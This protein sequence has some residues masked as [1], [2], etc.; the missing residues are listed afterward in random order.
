MVTTGEK[1]CGVCGSPASIFVSFMEGGFSANHAFCHLHAAKQGVLHPQG[2]D[3]LKHTVPQRAV[4]LACPRCAMTRSEFESRGRM[5][6]PGCYEAFRPTLLPILHKLHR[7][8]THK[9]KVPRRV[10][11]L[12]ILAHH[13][14]DLRRQMELAI[15]NES[16]EEAATL[17][18][19]IDELRRTAVA[20]KR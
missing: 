7:A 19:R 3:L 11:A 15:G 17:R 9:G 6:C 10:A 2:Y 14:I 1:C 16:F 18:D 12:R 4:L 8:G 13:I 5:G 20:H